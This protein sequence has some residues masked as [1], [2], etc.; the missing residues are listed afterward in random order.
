MSMQTGS[1]D[2]LP[3][4]TEELI[5]RQEDAVRIVILNR[6]EKRNALRISLRL[7]LVQALAEAGDDPNVGAV[8]LAG[9]G[10]AFCGGLDRSEFGTRAED[11]YASTEVLFNAFRD[12]P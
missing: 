10:P 1:S 12:H 8:V 6:P 5:T 2:T 7:E 3:V 11:L 4:V 9:E